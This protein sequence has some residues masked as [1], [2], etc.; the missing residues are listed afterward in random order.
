MAG[1]FWTLLWGGMLGLA[2]WWVSGRGFRQPDG[3]PRAL[4][5]AMLAW[6]WATLGALALGLA[7]F[8]ARG[9]LLAWAGAGLA[10]GGL[11]RALAPPAPRG[12]EPVDGP[13]D[14]AATIG[15]ALTL[16]AVAVLGATS[17]L[18]PVKVISDGPIYHLY[19]AARWWKSGR[20]AIIPAPFGDTAVSYLPADGELLFAALM[21]LDGGDLPARA[22]Q[23]PFL[24]LAA[25]SAF[26]IARRLGASMSAATLAVGLFVTCM[27]MLLYSFE[28]NVDSI[29]VAGYL[30]A[31]YEFLRY[32]QGDGRA[33]TLA[34][35]ALAAGGAWGSKVTGTVF[36]PPLQAVAAVAVVAR[37][38]SWRARVGHLLLLALLPW[39]MAGYWFAR[40]AWLTGN[41]IYP[42]QVSAF[43]RVWLRGWY[44][45]SAMRLS[46]FYLPPG[47][48]RL[49][50]DSLLSSF[51]PRLAPLWAVGLLGGWL[52]SRRRPEGRWIGVVAALAVADVALYWFLIPYRSQI[53]F[54]LP[55][56][57]LATAPLACLLD[58]ARW[59]RWTAVGLL[60]I[61]L[62]TPTLWPV[63][64][65]GRETT[66]GLSGRLNASSE[67]VIRAIPTPDQ[68]RLIRR[69]PTLGLNLGMTLASGVLA[70]LAARAWAS[71]R[72]HPSRVRRL[73]AAIATAAL[74]ALPCAVISGV[75]AGT[76]AVFPDAPL[77]RAWDRL[78]RLAGPRRARVAYAGTNFVYYLMGRGQRHDVAY[79][80]VDAHRGW[81]LH[82]Y[83]R[84]AI[85][86]GLPDWPDPR[87]GWDRLRTDYGAW[88]ANL[89]AER[90]DFLFVARPDPSDGRFNLADREGYPIE[91]VWADA[92]PEAFTLA[93]GPA[94][95]EPVARIYRVHP[96]GRPAIGP[97][98]SSRRSSR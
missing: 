66:W 83:H 3:L 67:G 12:A 23:V 46:P 85:S 21:A 43:G 80:N 41:P 27:P 19:F 11:V 47:D 28:A 30:V 58:R 54:L 1:A 96:S 84:E 38:G 34:L 86:Q 37:A 51:D 55:A 10:L 81:L 35:G 89:A 6:A 70:L 60:A 39:T 78:D 61:H 98:A 29:F 44:E 77:A 92:H 59:L 56:I 73:R 14:G 45:S 50:A 32:A 36:V 40:N 25:A 75:V 13:L 79:V 65:F 63:E 64:P 7:G 95:G 4:G 18:L 90:I 93:Y 82:D 33:G 57:G 53:R 31:A 76:E 88:L 17:L 20:L 42:L 5:A 69:Q 48:L 68:W 62:L 52:L 24:M 8:L 87:P 16:W 22:G 9:P 71:A 2:G 91:R 15:L 97:A 94:D 26:G 72:R 74:V 49:L